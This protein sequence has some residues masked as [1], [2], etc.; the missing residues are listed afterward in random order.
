MEDVL[1]QTRVKKAEIEEF[2]LK[3]RNKY[4]KKLDELNLE[5]VIQERIGERD[6]AV[7][8]NL[9]DL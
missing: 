4:A 3:A 7:I 2:L 5:A 8:V 9:E 6:K 1:E